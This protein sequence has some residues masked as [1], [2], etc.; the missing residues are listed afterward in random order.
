MNKALALWWNYAAVAI[1]ALGRHRVYAFVNLA[2]LALGLAACLIILLYVR[3]ERSYDS[4]LPD[5]DRVFQVQATWHE[6]GQPVSRSQASPFPVHDRLASGFPEIEAL[7]VL[8]AGQTVVMRGGA[9]LFLDAATVDKAFFDIFRLPFA[10]GSAATALPDTNSV[11]L[12]ESEAVNQLGTAYAV[13]R[14]ITIGAGGGKRDYRVSA[15]IRDLPKNSSLRLAVMFRNDPSEFDSWPEAD[16]G[17]GN[18]NQQH[19]VKLRSPADA[20]SINARLPAWEKKTIA[21]QT[22]GGRIAS[23]ADILDMKLVP[24]ADIHLGSAQRQAL[25]P[26]GDPRALATFGVVALLILGMAIM[27]FVN[28]STA[29]ATQRAREV[30]LR[31][32][33]GATR[34]Q[35]VVQL[36]GE[37]LLM[38]ALAMLIALAATEIA[39]PRIGALIGADL[40]VSYLGQGGILLP[41]VG[42]FLAAGLLGGFYP[43]VYLS[44]FQPAAVLRANKASAEAP[45][46]ARLRAALVILQFA[47]AIGLIVCTAFIYWQTRFVEAVDPGYRR[48]GLIQIDSAWRFAGDSTEYESARRE[49][50]KVPGVVAAGRTSLGLAATNRSIQAVK[51]PG[52]AAALSM[53]VY[54]VDPQ[55]FAAMDMRLLAGRFLGEAFARDRVM[56]SADTGA[57]ELGSGVN[58]VLNRNAASRLGF[59]DPRAA[60]GRTI[61]TGLDGS[62]DLAA[63]TVVGIVEDTR[64]RTARDAIEPIVYL[65]DPA[66]TYQVVVRY[67]AAQPGAV[68]DGL[69][70]VWR[71]FEPEIPFQGEFAEDLVG[72]QYASDRARGTLFAAFAGLAVIIACLGLYSL[73][74]FTTERRTKEIG[75]RKVLGAKVADIVKLLAWQFSKPV[76]VANVVAWPVAWWAM[77]DWLNGFDVRVPLTPGP[78]LLAGLI[79][80]AI[81]IG[82]VAG[83]AFRVARLNPIHALRYE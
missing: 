33:L 73:A 52:A 44:R 54:P 48:D 78:F 75:I 76:I 43:A 8:R 21:P 69:Q 32:V 61:G 6:A 35:L 2:G 58:V 53:G 79:A 26:G 80:L 57:L 63:A 19:Y 64:I 77:R 24:I 9:P 29:R 15:V 25:A 30:A 20:A 72:R 4:W 68:M 60:V 10:D 66:R 39:A 56:R 37:S 16:K 70:K 67:A 40:T 7:S 14:T 3:Y 55:F 13:G 36:L 5:S 12:T 27:N 62:D 51:A 11:V 41:A 65:Y 38:V 17:W 50:L 82:T 46:S 83:H 71:K 22:I 47:V 49:M 18:M 1:R 42:L 23:Q 28:L 45:G 59:N 34:G 81:A 31:K 74:S